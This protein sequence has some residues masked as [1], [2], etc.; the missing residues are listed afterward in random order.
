[1]TTTVTK[2]SSGFLV[3]IHGVTSN[4]MPQQIE[5]CQILN[6]NNTTIIT[7]SNFVWKAKLD[8]GNTVLIRDDLLCFMCPKNVSSTQ[9]KHWPIFFEPWKFCNDIKK[10]RDV[11]THAPA[12]PP[13]QSTSSTNDYTPPVLTDEEMT[14][15]LTIMM[16]YLDIVLR[17]NQQNEEML[18]ERI[19]MHPEIVN[20]PIFIN[21]FRVQFTNRVQEW[22][23][24]CDW[25][26]FYDPLVED[27]GY[28]HL[29]GNMESH[30]G[31]I[32]KWGT[33]E[34]KAEIQ[35]EFERHCAQYDRLR[36][37]METGHNVETHFDHLPVLQ[38]AIDAFESYVSVM[39]TI[40]YL[41]QEQTF[42]NDEQS[43]NEN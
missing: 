13:Q 20:D 23:M 3:E 2:T 17:L 32:F 11:D 21:N 19:S 4:T 24:R 28:R 6:D 18:A 22:K 38:S 36:T 40:Q 16:P 37:M 43:N 33:D 30:Y 15:F 35:E 10:N 42:E 1:M 7:N 31:F 41:Q 12:P 29:L 9:Q 25:A 14:Q 8:D 39:E 5:F 27:G 26:K 34:E